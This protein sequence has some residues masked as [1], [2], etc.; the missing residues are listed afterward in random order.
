MHRPEERRDQVRV[1]RVVW[2]DDSP[3]YQGKSLPDLED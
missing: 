1:G 3:G 2:K